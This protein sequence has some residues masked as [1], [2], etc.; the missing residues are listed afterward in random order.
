MTETHLRLK[1]PKTRLVKSFV[2]SDNKKQGE[3]TTMLQW[4]RSVLGAIPSETIWLYGIAMLI[5]SPGFY[6][7]VYFISVGYAFSITAMAIAT[8]IWFRAHLE[9]FT[10]LHCLALGLYG[11]R[12][13]S[14]LIS[15]EFS[16][17]YRKELE[18]VQKRA[19]NITLPK[20]FA[21]WLGVSV[22]YVLMFSP[23]LFN[24]QLLRTAPKTFLLS[25]PIGL[26]IMYAGLLLEA[27]ADKQKSSFKREHPKQ[28]CNV[29]LY[30]WVRCPNYLG[31]IV[32]WV[33]NWVAGLSG[34]AHWSHWLLSLAGLL[35]II[36][37]MMGSTKRLEHKQ[38][39]R[40]GDDPAYQEYTRSVPV[41][42]PFVPL[43]SLKKVR[44]YLE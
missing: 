6:R 20:K 11:I 10:I 35:C 14:Y 44:V 38:D 5:S 15:R 31:E 17:S 40:Y 27:L 39:E 3:A 28:F 23:C 26:F 1:H 18:E 21:I 34:F 22:L 36:L 43:Y 41:L 13:G 12:L 29:G 37:I 42:L 9:L 16:P 24:L 19:T 25:L 4:L 32:F 8:A 33:G 7:L 30:R 2:A